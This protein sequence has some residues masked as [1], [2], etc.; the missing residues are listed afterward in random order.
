MFELSAINYSIGY[1]L[2]V[3]NLKFYVDKLIVSFACSTVKT[4]ACCLV[5]DPVFYV[6]ENLTGLFAMVIARQRLSFF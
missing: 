6:S 1:V 3:S 4:F 2:V 5:I